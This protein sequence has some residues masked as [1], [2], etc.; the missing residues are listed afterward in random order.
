MEEDGQDHDSVEDD[1]LRQKEFRRGSGID[2]GQF[3]I[4]EP[5][6]EIEIDET[7]PEEQTDEAVGEIASLFSAEDEKSSEPGAINRDGTVDEAAAPDSVTEM[8][9][10]GE[11]RLGF[12]LLAG[13]V[14]VWSFLDGLLVLRYRHSLAFHCSS[15][16][17]CPDY[18]LA[19]NGFRILPCTF[20]A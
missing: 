11:R 16:W 7:A 14:L 17:V 1:V 5:E 6:E 13:M 19:R 3:M 9:V 15:S 2:L 20:S 8:A 10:H 18:G 4:Q 12:G